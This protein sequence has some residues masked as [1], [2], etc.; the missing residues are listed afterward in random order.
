MSALLA[1][2]GETRNETVAMLGG[3]VEFERDGSFNFVP[4]D[5]KR[6]SLIDIQI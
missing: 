1:I 2:L 6:K 3:P 5:R 4:S